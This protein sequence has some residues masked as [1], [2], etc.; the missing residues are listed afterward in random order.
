MWP[1]VFVGV[2][3]RPLQLYFLTVAECREFTSLMKFLVEDFG[4][5]LKL[6]SDI[7]TFSWFNGTFLLN[8]AALILVI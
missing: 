3:V 2:T 6:V 7:F 4:F 1:K 8:M 5:F